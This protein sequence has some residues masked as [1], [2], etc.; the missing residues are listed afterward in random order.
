MRFEVVE[1]GWILEPGK[2][3]KIQIYERNN[4]LKIRV[5]KCGIN[6]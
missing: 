6:E 5:E 2:I 4:K 1:Q 3:K